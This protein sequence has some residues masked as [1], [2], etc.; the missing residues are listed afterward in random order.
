MEAGGG[1]G[2]HGGLLDGCGHRGG[3]GR[4][5]LGGA[6][7]R[8]E[9]QRGDGATPDGSVAQGG[10]SR[11]SGQGPPRWRANIARPAPCARGSGRVRASAPPRHSTR[12]APAA[13]ARHRSRTAGSAARPRALRAASAS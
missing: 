2:G 11:R 7:G 4:R 13:P 12:P 10:V 3:P 9:D 6:A 1:S 5:A 8:Q